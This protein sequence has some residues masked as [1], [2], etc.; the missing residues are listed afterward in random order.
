VN[1]S[2]YIWLAIALLVVYLIWRSKGTGVVAKTLRAS[3][4]IDAIMSAY[5]VGDYAMGLEKAERLKDGSVKSAEYC[6]FRGLLLH[7]LGDLSDAEASLREALPLHDEPRQRALVLNSLASVLMDQERFTEA[8]A[9]YENAGRVWPDRGASL[10]GISE[11]WLRQGRESPEAL[12]QARRAVEIDR[13]A[14]GMGK[15]A[16][17]CR[18]GEDLAV[19]AWALAANSADAGEVDSALAEGFR[20]CG[21]RTKSILAQ[22]HYHAGRAYLALQISDKSQEHFRRASEIDPQGRFGRMARST[23]SQSGM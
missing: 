6:M 2:Q 13:H 19:L 21:V 15:E 7:Q 8:I 16:L 23:L 17:E 11:V 14:T 18:L 20:L 9:F 10:R 12:E 3:R 1:A 5:R 4:T 22:V